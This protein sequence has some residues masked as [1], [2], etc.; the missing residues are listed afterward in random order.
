MSALTY[1]LKC[2]TCQK[3]F[4]TNRGFSR[5]NNTI[6]KLNKLSVEQKK[7]PVSIIANIKGDIVYS[8]HRR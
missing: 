8:I 6:H 5:H 2:L 1:K 3:E 4:K 7:I